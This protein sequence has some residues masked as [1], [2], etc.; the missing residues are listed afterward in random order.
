MIR[1]NQP[2]IN[3]HYQYNYLGNQPQSLSGIGTSYSYD[4]NGNMTY[5][6]LRDFFIYYNNLLNLPQTISKASESIS[7][8]YSANG[9]KLAK[10]M[11]DNSCQHY[12]D[13]FLPKTPMLMLDPLP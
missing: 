6:G 2:G 12:A 10:R 13:G 5:D 9:E 7:Y 1:S 4:Q 11:K 3:T 8:I